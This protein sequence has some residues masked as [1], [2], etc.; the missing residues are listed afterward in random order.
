MLWIIPTYPP[1]RNVIIPMPS[2]GPRSTRGTRIGIPT[3]VPTSYTS[4]RLPGYPGTRVTVC[5][6]GGQSA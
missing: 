6:F 5:I 4:H 1:G 2:P 3:R